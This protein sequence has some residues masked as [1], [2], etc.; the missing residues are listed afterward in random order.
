METWGHR[1]RVAWGLE[2]MGMHNIR[3]IRGQG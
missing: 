1:N 3:G 2:D